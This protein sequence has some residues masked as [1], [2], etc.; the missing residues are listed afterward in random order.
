MCFLKVML[1]LLKLLQMQTC[2][3]RPWVAIG[4]PVIMLHVES[5]TDQGHC[6]FNT[7]RNTM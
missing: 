4:L 6:N 1:N 2:I 7:F 5:H 3:V